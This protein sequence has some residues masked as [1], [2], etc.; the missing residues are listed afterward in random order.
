MLW[1]SISQIQTTAAGRERHRCPWVYPTH[2]DHQFRFACAE[3]MISL[4]HILVAVDFSPISL[5][6]L[7]HALEIAYLFRSSVSVLHVI[8]CAIYGM[9][10]DGISAEMECVLRECYA[11][12][13][14]LAKEDRLKEIV[15]NSIV[16]VGPVWPTIRKLIEELSSDL[17]VM[18]THGRTGVRKLLLGSGKC[19]QR[20]PMSGAD[21]RGP[22]AAVEMSGSSGKAFSCPDG[23]VMPFVGR[24]SLRAL[25]G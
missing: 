5:V 1:V 22:C 21:S 7:R 13:A 24:A 19:V 15:F 3:A 18:G 16:K 2:L 11:L 6:A 8:D 9:A 25:F 17:L 12:E 14:N 4:R 20:Q 23:S 10:P